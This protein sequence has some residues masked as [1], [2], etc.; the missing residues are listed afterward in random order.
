[1][2]TEGFEEQVNRLLKIIDVR[3]VAEALLLAYEKPE[4]G[5]RYICTAHMIKL[6]DL[7][8]ILKRIYPNYNYPKK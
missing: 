5:G 4:A 6:R 2:R 8:E 7:V 1:M 3:D